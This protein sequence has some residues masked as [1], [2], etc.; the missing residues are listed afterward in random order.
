MLSIL[1]YALPCPVCTKTNSICTTPTP[2]AQRCPIV[3]LNI[4]LLD[5]DELFVFRD[6][7]QQHPVL[8]LG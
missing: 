8:H 7:N 2:S 1:H 5:I 6:R 4:N 3:L